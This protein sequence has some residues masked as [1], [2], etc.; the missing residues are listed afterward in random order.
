MIQDAGSETQCTGAP[1]HMCTKFQDF[2][3]ILCSVFCVLHSRIGH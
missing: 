2:N 3:F 1:V